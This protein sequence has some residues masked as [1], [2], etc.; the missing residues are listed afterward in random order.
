MS[1]NQKMD[2]INQNKINS[3]SFV[4]RRNS[5]VNCLAK[6]RLSS[7]KSGGN[8]I[9]FKQSNL[10]ESNTILKLPQNNL[11]Q[12][13]FSIN[14][15]SE[16]NDGNDNDND[17]TQNPIKNSIC[18]SFHLHIPH[19]DKTNSRSASLLCIKYENQ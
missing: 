15:S 16:L 9:N 19:L 6:K 11:S 12:N 17:N 3:Q 2:K 7:R 8:L 5:R 13:K 18:S 14:L 1:V 10:N 4:K